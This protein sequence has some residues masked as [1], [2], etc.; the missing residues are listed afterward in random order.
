MRIVWGM[1]LAMAG[2]FLAFAVTIKGAYAVHIIGWIIL[3][4]GLFALVV[5]VIDTVSTQRRELVTRTE[6]VRHARSPDH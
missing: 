3:L 5:G 4:A 1:I 2:A 6:R